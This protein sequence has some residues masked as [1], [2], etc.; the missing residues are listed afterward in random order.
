M[1]LTCS[2]K[3][4][5]YTP[6]TAVLTSRISFSGVLESFPHEFAEMVSGVVSSIRFCDE[7]IFHPEELVDGGKARCSYVKF[8]QYY[9]GQVQLN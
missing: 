7:R 3:R 2:T 8:V 9:L 4:V 5:T 6:H 1:S